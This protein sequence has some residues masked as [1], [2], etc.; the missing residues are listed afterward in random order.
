MKQLCP[1]PALYTALLLVAGLN[2]PVAAI[3]TSDV[4]GSHAVAPGSITFGVNADGVVGL[5]NADSLTLVSGSLIADRYILTAAHIVDANFDGV[6]DAVPPVTKA[7]FDLSTGPVFVDLLFQEAIIAPAWAA[8]RTSG[9][10]LAVIPLAADAPLSVPRYQLNALTNEVGRQGVI[11]GYGSSGWGAEGIDAFDIGTKRAGLNRVEARG[12]DLTALG[13]AY[14]PDP[15]A[16]LVYDFDSGQSTNNALSR[17]GISSDLGFGTDEVG[18]A[19]GDSGGP[20]FIDGLLAAVM[21]NVIGRLPS[22]VTPGATDSSWGELMIGVRVSSFEEFILSAT[23]GEAVFVPQPPIPIWNVD[24]DGNW[25]QASNWTG[26]VPNAVGAGAIFGSVIT[27]PRTVTLD[28]PI[29]VG[30]IDFANAN[31]YTIAGS[32]TL[33]LDATS[34]QTQLNVTSGSHTISAPVTLA[35]N[36]AVTVTPP[37]S[38]LSITGPLNATGRNL[39]KAGAGTLTVNHFRG[40]VLSVNGGTVAIAA[41]GGDEGTSVVTGLSIAGAAGAWTAKL[42]LNNNDAVV[43]STAANKAADFARLY[44]QLKQGFN[45]GTWQVWASPAPP[46]LPIPTPTQGW[47]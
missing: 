24:A 30:R 35:D 36:M 37:A 38:N 14:M 29:R 2:D 15:G 31:S 13:D 17:L 8:D 39:T 45:N 1:R 16:T 40:A 7:R 41:N 25:S 9:V 6:V 33:T 5:A 19:I 28:A 10:D 27:A 21:T 22:D 43:Q 44:N 46:P 11:V 4:A 23:G 47:P 20:L 12:E 42:D 18:V 32:N 34:G 3:V 26:G